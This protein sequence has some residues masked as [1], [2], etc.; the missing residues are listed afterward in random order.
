MIDVHDPDAPPP[1]RMMCRTCRRV[2]TFTVLFEDIAALGHSEPVGQVEIHQYLHP[3]DADPGHDPDPVPVTPE[4]VLDERCDFCNA[5]EVAGWAIATP[6]TVTHVGFE[7]RDDG[8]WACCTACL[9]LLE[10]RKGNRLVNRSI[11]LAVGR[12]GP[13]AE[14]PTRAIQEAFLRHFT[15]ETTPL[16]S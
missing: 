2:L 4:A 10:A 11:A 15:G 9:A 6:F 14:G 7:H 5:T 1:P 13:H 3:G 12:H 8:I 16:S